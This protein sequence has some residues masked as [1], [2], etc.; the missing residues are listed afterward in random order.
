MSAHCRG[1]S[2]TARARTLAFFVSNC[3]SFLSFG[4]PPQEDIA[5]AL[6]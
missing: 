5:I 1:G 2:R 6:A 4:E 3:V